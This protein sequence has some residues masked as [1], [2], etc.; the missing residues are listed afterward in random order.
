[1]M[2]QGDSS[3]VAHAR[4]SFLSLFSPPSLC[5]RS[6]VLPRDV[7]HAP[8]YYSFL[9][10]SLFMCRTL[11][12]SGLL[13]SRGDVIHVLYNTIPCYYSFLIH[14]SFMRR[15]LHMLH[16]HIIHVSHSFIASCVTLISCSFVGL[17]LRLCI[18][19]SGLEPP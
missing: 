12:V 16:L 11:S 9:I 5:F 15:I 17:S 18:S 2:L 4:L 19:Q 3:M 6:S 1:M 10:H 13:F 7:I 14:L 8:C